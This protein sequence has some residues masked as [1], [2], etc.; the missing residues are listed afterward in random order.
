MGAAY[1]EPDAILYTA[2][3]NAAAEIKGP[4]L[5]QKYFEEMLLLNLEPTAWT[6]RTLLKAWFRARN[7]HGFLETFQR[8]QSAGFT[9]DVLQYTQAF[10]CLSRLNRVGEI[11][12]ILKDMLA[13]R[14]KT[15]AKCRQTLKDIF[16]KAEYVRISDEFRIDRYGRAGFNSF[17][18]SIEQKQKAKLDNMCRDQ[19]KSALRPPRR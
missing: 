3:M 4:E 18:S 10:H 17:D 15:D 13:R 6:Y 1:V 7:M 12:P 8:M 11:E 9:P 14:V 16:G 19:T 5:A 2:M